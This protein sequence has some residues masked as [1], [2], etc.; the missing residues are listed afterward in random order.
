MIS[1]EQYVKFLNE[2]NLP[3]YL[4]IAAN[5]YELRK[6]YL[7][8]YCKAQNCKPRIVESIDFKN[9]ARTL[10]VPEVQ[11]LVDYKPAIDKPKEEYINSSKLIVYLYTNTKWI[12]SAVD[13]FYN[14]N[15][16]VINDLT[17]TQAENL[18]SRKGLDDSIIEYLSENIESPTQMRLY[19]LQILLNAKELNMTNIECFEKLYKN[20]L[21]S[22]L[23][24]EPTPFLDA[25]LD[26]NYSFVFEYLEAQKYNE[27]YVY[28]AIFRWL[29]NVLRFVAC[30]RD[31]WNTG[32]LVKAVYG[33]L[34]NKGLEKVPWITWIHIYK[35]GIQLRDQIKLT[36]R[37]PLSALEVYVCYIIQTLVEHQVIKPVTA[38]TADAR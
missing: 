2:G 15:V 34:Q 37:D 8:L 5:D 7:N 10:G 21:R 4:V 23:S 24:E 16:I 6:I 18:L 29:E 27:F 17:R 35:L 33:P 14:G 25:I 36:E 38:S 31:Y 13:K 3:K 30:N 32:G 28:A 19:G 22:E 1:P 26:S 9:K 11:V 20:D 12:T